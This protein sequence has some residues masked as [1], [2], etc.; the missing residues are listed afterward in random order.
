M[1]KSIN[2]SFL[3]F[4]L[5]LSAHNAFAQSK[6]LAT[7]ENELIVLYS[8][9]FKDSGKTGKPANV[10]AKELVKVLK[11]NPATL[12]YPFKKLVSKANCYINTSADGKFRIY[13]WDTWTGGTM[14]LYNEIYQW[15]DNSKIF[16]KVLKYVAEEGDAGSFCSKIYTVNINHKNYYLAISNSIYSTRDALQ[17]ISVFTIDNG[18]LNDSVELFKTRTEKLN[19]IRVEYNFFSVVDRSERP[20]ELI[21]YD[22]KR[23]IVYV[24]VVDEQGTVSTRNLLYQLKGNYFEYIGIETGKRK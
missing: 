14:R 21:S 1:I 7:K 4:L 20:V 18:K 13:S 16:T 3:V 23:K 22:E 9:L 10:F 15:S 2:I 19:S 11:E 17:S 24:A 6:S 12:A 8:K 5:V